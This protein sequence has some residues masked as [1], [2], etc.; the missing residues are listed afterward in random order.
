MRIGVVG[1]TTALK[2]QQQGTYQVA[3]VSEVL[4]SDP[5]TIRYTSRWAVRSAA[6]SYFVH[7][8]QP[9]NSARVH[10][11]FII[12]STRQ[13]STVS[14]LWLIPWALTT[15][16]LLIPHNDRTGRRNIQRHVGI[17]FLGE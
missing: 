17:I 14:I 16:A 7:L 1:L 9:F 4:P 3:I 8:T 15:G 2:L 13:I 12:L 11:M 10:T 6:L 5:K